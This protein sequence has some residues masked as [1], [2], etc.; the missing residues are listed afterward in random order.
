MGIDDLATAV[1]PHIKDL[2]RLLS[3]SA[4]RYMG[5]ELWPNIVEQIKDPVRLQR[6]GGFRR[7]ELR[8]IERIIEENQTLLLEAWDE[9]FNP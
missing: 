6:T 7:H 5:T 2:L 3:H 9:R 1:I 4:S 8:R